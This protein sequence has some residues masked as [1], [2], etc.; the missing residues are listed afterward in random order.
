MQPAIQ[1]FVQSKRLAVVGVSRNP[2]KFGNLAYNELKARGYQVFAFTPALQNLAGDPCYPNLAALTGQVDGVVVCV[3][4]QQGMQVLREAAA[5][6]V[7]KVWVQQQA[8]SAELL[9]L[10]QDLGLN[11]VSGKCILMYAEP[12]RSFHAFHRFFARIFGQL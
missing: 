1:E 11:L 12:V 2:N 5:A 9:A 6:G 3:P 7:S 4:P 8:D 10:G